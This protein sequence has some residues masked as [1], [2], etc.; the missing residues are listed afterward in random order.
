MMQTKY[1]VFVFFYFCM[2]FCVAGFVSPGTVW[3]GNTPVLQL[4]LKCQLV[5]QKANGLS[6]DDIYTKKQMEKGISKLQ[7]LA[8]HPVTGV[9]DEEVL[10]MVE[11]NTCPQKTPKQRTRQGTVSRPGGAG[12]RMYGV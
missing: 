5:K 1:S 3:V 4:L 11:R 12:G 8:G 10:K 2:N 6:T 7:I 9:A